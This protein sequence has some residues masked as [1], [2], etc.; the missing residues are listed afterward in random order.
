[1]FIPLVAQFLM[2]IF[3]SIY[4]DHRHPRPLEASKKENRAKGSRAKP[5]HLTN[6]ARIDQEGSNRSEKF[7]IRYGD[8]KFGKLIAK[9]ARELT[10]QMC[11][12]DPGVFPD[13]FTGRN[14]QLLR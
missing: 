6:V 4:H 13:D 14:I 5:T 7:N 12:C 1:M 2:T 3:G 8:K 11:R 10:F 9:M